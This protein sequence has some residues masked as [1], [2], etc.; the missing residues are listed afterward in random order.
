MSKKKP[1]KKIDAKK[2]EAK[3]ASRASDGE[4]S[5]EQLEQAAGGTGL[6]LDPNISAPN[7]SAAPVVETNI[8]NVNTKLNL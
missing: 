5:D 2:K 7:V 6:L 8:G 3:P 4:L 1:P